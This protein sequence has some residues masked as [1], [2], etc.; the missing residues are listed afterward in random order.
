MVLNL[1]ENFDI[2]SELCAVKRTKPKPD[3]ES[4]PVEIYPNMP[5]HTVENEYTADQMKDETEDAN[6]SKAYNSKVD[7][8]G[9]LTHISCQHNIVKGFTALYKGESALQ[10]HF[11]FSFFTFYFWVHQLYELLF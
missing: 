2:K 10:V 5:E 4:A 6:C 9:G 3:H 1:R 8:T 7:I 11:I